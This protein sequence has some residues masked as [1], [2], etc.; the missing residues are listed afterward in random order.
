ML[1]FTIKQATIRM[2]SDLLRFF[3]GRLR[4]NRKELS[5][6]GRPFEL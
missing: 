5:T 1:T 6:L 3:N 2:Y 4:Q